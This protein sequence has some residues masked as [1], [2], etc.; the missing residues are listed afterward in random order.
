MGTQVIELITALQER[1]SISLKTT[2]AAVPHSVAK[3]NATE[4]NWLN[5]LQEHLPYRYRANK[6]FVIDS[7]GDSSEQIDI[8]IYDRQYTPPLYNKD[9]QLYI[10]A[11]SVYAV[12]EVKQEINKEIVEYAG[13]KAESVRRLTRTNAPIIHAGGKFEPRLLFPI[14]GGILAYESSWKP[15]FGDP[16]YSALASLPAEQRIELGYVVTSGFFDVTYNDSMTVNT[17]GSNLG[18]A[19]FL[20]R[21]LECLQSLGTVPAIDY[22]KYLSAITKTG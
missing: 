6:A 5:M 13:A 12:F 20:F 22:S 19:Y 18:L 11:E 9:E 1:L 4:L 21:L 10:P 2:R 15:L 16:F 17:F 7:N 14:M 8:V 3:G